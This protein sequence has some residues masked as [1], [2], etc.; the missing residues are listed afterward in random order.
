LATVAVVKPE[1]RLALSS[2]N[3]SPADAIALARWIL[4]TFSDGPSA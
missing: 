2:A 1:M 4:D 3:I